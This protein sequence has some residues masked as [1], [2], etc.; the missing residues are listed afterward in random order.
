MSGGPPDRA[1]EWRPSL[2]ILV[3]TWRRVDEVVEAAR[4]VE[5]VDPDVEIVVVD[6]GSEAAIF[7]RLREALAPFP[8]VAL[9]RNETNLGMVRNWN[10]CIAHARGEWMG[11]LCSDD[12]YVPGAVARVRRL[13]SELKEPALIMWDLAAREAETRLPPGPGT[14]RRIPI[15]VASGH[16]WHR[17]VAA[18]VGP[19]DERFEYS[20]D[21]EFWPRCAVR[22]PVVVVRE[23]LAEYRRHADNYM[24][25]TWERPNFLSQTELLIR[26][27]LAHQYAD[28]PPNAPAVEERLDEALWGTLISIVAGSF[29]YRGKGHLFRRYFPLAVRRAR[30]P[31]R[32]LLVARMLVSALVRRLRGRPS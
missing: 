14:A 3:P 6:N 20:A 15:H 17:R 13:M 23:P 31:R 26:T 24:W 25:S 30:T 7:E 18:T 19:F 5:T 16:F 12:V 9:Y 1:R 29:L 21:A 22:F 4:S 8:N 2:S 27:I 10:R 11:L 32:Q 28:A